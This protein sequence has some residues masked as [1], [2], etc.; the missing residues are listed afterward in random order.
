MPG[1][2]DM[3]YPILRSVITGFNNESIIIAK[4]TANKRAAKYKIG[5]IIILKATIFEN[6]LRYL[7]LFSLCSSKVFEKTVSPVGFD[8]KYKYS[9]CSGLSTALIEEI[10]GLPMGDGGNPLFL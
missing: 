3:P 9:D 1:N 10:L 7:A 6:Y 8:K 5:E 4:K 2:N